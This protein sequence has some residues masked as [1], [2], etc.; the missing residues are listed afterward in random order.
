M[1]VTILVMLRAFSIGGSSL[2][3]VE[4]VSDSADVFQKPKGLNAARAL[5]VMAAV[6]GS[7]LLGV[8]WLAYAT[9]ATPYLEEYPSVL[10][11]VVHV[12]F[13]SGVLGNLLF[14]LVM[15]ATA[16]ILFAGANTGFS[17]FSALASVVRDRVPPRPPTHRA[18]RGVLASGIV[19]A[20]LSILLLLLTR[21]LVNYLVSLYALPVFIAFSMTGYAMT[22]YHR[23][24]RN[25]AGVG[26]SR[27]AWWRGLCRRSWQRSS[28]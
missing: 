4:A 20:L 17:R 23:T 28:R 10:S 16:A 12:V 2:T 24:H 15:A 7:L 14:F 11:Q 8:A 22:K 9:H 25:P 3:G 19:L 26:T 27:L 13:G 6:L 5:T 21:G 1:V 18:D